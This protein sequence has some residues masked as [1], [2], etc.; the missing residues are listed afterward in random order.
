MRQVTRERAS[1]TFSFLRIYDPGA[2]VAPHR[3]HPVARWNI[4]LVVGGEPPPSRRTA[5]PFWIAARPGRRAVRLGLGDAVLHRGTHLTHWRA[6]QPAGRS[7]VLACFHYG[8][9]N[10]G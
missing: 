7:T 8:P 10:S 5:W 2:A 3:D 1:S 9:G 4:D 6:A